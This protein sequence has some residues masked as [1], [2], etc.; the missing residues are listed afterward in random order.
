MTVKE[1]IKKDLADR[2]WWNEIANLFDTKVM[3]WTYRQTAS[4]V[5]GINIDDDRIA[6]VLRQLVEIT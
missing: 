6:K 2:D 3:R 5:N 4:F 1:E